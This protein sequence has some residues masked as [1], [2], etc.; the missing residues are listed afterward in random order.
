[1]SIGNAWNGCVRCRYCVYDLT[2]A[3]SHCMHAMLI[4]SFSLLRQTDRDTHTRSLTCCAIISST[5]TL[6]LWR[7]D[8]GW[9][10][11]T[12]GFSMIFCMWLCVSYKTKIKNTCK[13]SSI[14]VHLIHLMVRLLFVCSLIR[15]SFAIDQNQIS[16]NANNN[17]KMK[18]RNRRKRNT[19]THRFTAV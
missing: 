19:H 3:P 16:G 15:L 1:M 17:D 10:P 18:L 5:L 2:S 13:S 8:N 6:W 11:A 7:R 14:Y 9:W 4:H 12:C